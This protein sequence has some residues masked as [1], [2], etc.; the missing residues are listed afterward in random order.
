MTHEAIF[1]LSLSGTDETTGQVLMARGEYPASA[2]RW[3][4]TF[5]DILERDGSAAH[6][7]QQVPRRRPAGRG[8]PGAAAP[9]PGAPP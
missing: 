5:R 4:A 6:R 9:S 2:I 8:T 1:I 3:N 7:L